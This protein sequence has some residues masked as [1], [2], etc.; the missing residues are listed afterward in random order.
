MNVVFF[1]TPHFV[2]PV[3]DRLKEHFNLTTVVS[4]PDA[5]SGR[6]QIL[7]PTPVKIYA[8]HHNIAVLTPQEFNDEAVQQLQKL[9]PDIFVTAG[10]GKLIPQTIIDMPKYGSLNIHPSLLPKYRGASPV[11]AA[12][13]HGDTETGVTIIK[14][15]NQMDHGPILAQEKVTIDTTDTSETL[16][17]KLF[18]LGAEILINTLTN[19]VDGKIKPTPQDDSK[20]TYTWKTQESKQKAYFDNNNPPSKEQFDAM[21]RA[22]YPWPGVWTTIRIMNQELRIKF[23]PNKQVQIEGKKPVDVETFIRGYSEAKP[24]MEKLFEV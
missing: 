23:L 6:Q 21:V 5:V 16:Y 9:N 17:K 4:T 20:A 2:T 7:T 24:L 13:L 10:Y 3:I 22:F 12:I 11:Q 14:M 18:S 8:T 1:G 15:D 19:Y